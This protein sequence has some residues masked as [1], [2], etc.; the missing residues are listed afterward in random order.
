MPTADALQ[1]YCFLFASPCPSMPLS[2]IFRAFG[3]KKIRKQ[4]C[5]AATLLHIVGSLMKLSLFL[6]VTS[7][8]Q[9]LMS[10]LSSSICKLL[11]VGSSFP[12]LAYLCST[13]PVSLVADFAWP[14]CGVSRF[15]KL[16]QW[17]TNPVQNLTKEQDFS[18]GGDLTTS[19]LG[20]TPSGSSPCP[21]SGCAL[22]SSQRRLLSI[23]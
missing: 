8:V 19:L 3:G 21:E 13:P 22:C 11:W 14:G 16:T 20:P 7:L 23:P 1:C 15:T 18:S 12:R 10:Q 5:G 4:Q 17:Q 9:G 6:L 2:T